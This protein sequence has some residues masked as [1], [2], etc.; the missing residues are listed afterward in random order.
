MSAE[1][2]HDMVSG[3]SIEDR[4]IYAT[5]ALIGERGLGGVTMS[6]VAATANVARQTLYNHYPDVDTIVAAAIE[7]HNRESVELLDAAMRLVE[8]PGD[9]L[10]QLVRHVVSIGAHAHHNLDLSDGL[11]AGNRAAVAGYEQAIERYVSG[12]LEEGMGRGVFREDLEPA[13]DAVLIGRVLDGLLG[14]AAAAPDDSAR[15]ARAGA[16]TIRAAVAHR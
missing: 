16:R 14:L 8:M 12:A 5:L 2:A 9:K 1:G 4:I 15:I 10:E 11:S 3:G 6:A 7:R 13:I